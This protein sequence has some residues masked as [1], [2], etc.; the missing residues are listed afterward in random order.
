ML[1][2]LNTSQHEL[3][4]PSTGQKVKYRPFLVKE[5]K[6]L[7]IAQE[8]GDQGAI[9]NAV[10]DLVNTCTEGSISNVEKLPTFDV[11]YIFLK[12]RSQSVG[13]VVPLVV[14]CED[15]GETKVDVQV[16]LDEIK[17]D[18][19]KSDNVIKITDSIGI[20]LRYPDTRTIAK[21]SDSTDTIET[22]F[23]IMSDCVVNI[24]DEN[25]IYDEMSKKELDDFI[26][27]MTATQFQKLQDFFESTP[28]L[29]HTVNVTNP[30]T[31]VENK[32]VIEGLANFL[33]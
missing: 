8:S 23:G 6:I 21:Y 1:P 17:I 26:E 3:V 20:T 12:I 32:I 27:S 29:S 15:D 25:E 16:N 13:S 14:T 18:V 19:P 10:C 2:Q 4:V 9:I 11:E 31:G 28:R 33:E 24:F 30:N 5:Q 7:M 22:T